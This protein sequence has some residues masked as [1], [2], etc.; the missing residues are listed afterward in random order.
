MLNISEALSRSPVWSRLIWDSILQHFCLLLISSVTPEF[1]S[2]AFSPAFPCV[3]LCL[4]LPGYLPTR[5]R[6]VC[7]PV[8]NLHVYDLSSTCKDSKHLSVYTLN[9]ITLIYLPALLHFAHYCNKNCCWTLSI[10]L[11]HS[12]ITI[13]LEHFIIY[14]KILFV[15]GSG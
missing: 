11:S 4:A 9:P 6:G 5:R 1:L 8:S 7:I 10:S 3:S 15:V 2:P 12:V 13:F 14:S